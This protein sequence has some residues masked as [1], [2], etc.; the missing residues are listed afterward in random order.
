MIEQ[1][2]SNTNKNV[3]LSILRKNLELNKALARVLQQFY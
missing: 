3:I 2:L 1:Y